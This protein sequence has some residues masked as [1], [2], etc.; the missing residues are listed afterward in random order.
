M[1]NGFLFDRTARVT[2]NRPVNRLLL[3]FFVPWLP[4][5]LLSRCFGKFAQAHLPDPLRKIVLSGFA[6]LYHLKMEEAD[7]PLMSYPTL[8]ALFTRHLKP[9]LRPILADWVHP[10]DGVLSSHGFIRENQGFQ[11][12]GW[13]YSITKL[14]GRETT[15]FEGGI[16]LTYYLCPTDYH[17]I[18]SPVT[19]KID[20]LCHLQGQLWPV[21]AWSVGRIRELFCV[22]ERVVL[23]YET[24]KGPLAMVMV[25]ATNVG[26]IEVSFD[27]S[28]HTNVGAEIGRP[29]FKTYDPPKAVKVGD[30]VGA[31]HMGST[32]I[33]LASREWTKSFVPGGPKAVRLGESV[34]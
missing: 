4:K 12:K 28:I 7:R 13:T 33:V 2:K 9:C 25:G 31:F 21:N 32:V 27:A 8:D 6:K 26:Q 15:E 5:R 23:N 14:L 19:G 3:S 16:F 30:G 24:A 1:W 18:H 10:C 29:V 20:S 17:R 22:N 11:A 34:L